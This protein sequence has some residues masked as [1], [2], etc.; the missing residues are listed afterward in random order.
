MRKAMAWATALLALPPGL[1]CAGCSSGPG[2]PESK[3][4][5]YTSKESET[6]ELFTVPK[7]QMAHLQ[8]I[9]VEKTKL[10]RVLR[11]TGSVAYNQF[12]TTPVFPAIGGPV[13]EILVAPG[14][15]VQVGAPLLT[16]NSPD[17]ALARAAYIK[18][19]EAL[20]LADKILHRARDLYAHGAI[21]E[22]DLQQAESSRT[23]AE[24]DM[25]SSQDAL[26]A[27]GIKDPDSVAKNTGKTTLQIPLLA[28]VNGEVVERL[29]GPGQLLQNGVTQCFTI[30]DMSQ[31][32]V[33][34]NVYQS[35]MP[36]VHA[37]QKVEINTESYPDTFHGEISY[38][39]PA[40]D[41]NTRTVQARIVTSN[42]AKKLKKDMYVVASVQA[43]VNPDALTI[44]DAALL[45]DTEN[46]PYVYVQTDTNRF[47]R[48]LVKFGGSNAG[49]TEITDGLKEGERL[50]GDGALF[51]Q[52]KNSLQH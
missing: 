32:W 16:I 52:F 43:G 19:K 42:P 14:Q 6:A 17:Y 33:L 15:S 23:Q 35:E 34:V 51:L 18:A 31:V 5:S 24:A 4:T 40:L 30:S 2:E 41:P 48:R 20:Q 45:R 21:S 36:Y 27:L 22:A 29:V 44:P 37:G 47:A 50:V 12:K 25:V 1:A 9:T 39:A 10:Q 13:H 49:R 8:V 46:Q 7:D 38:I 11:L 3:M 28:P 26:R